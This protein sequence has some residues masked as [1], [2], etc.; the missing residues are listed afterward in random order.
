MIGQKGD[1]PITMKIFFKE[2]YSDV[3]VLTEPAEWR[4]WSSKWNHRSIYR[5]I[6][7]H[8]ADFYHH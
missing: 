1:C 4:N 3:G 8:R 2:K 7:A 6:S 5:I